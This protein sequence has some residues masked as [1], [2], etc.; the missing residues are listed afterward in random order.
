[1]NWGTLVAAAF[2]AIVGVGTTLLTDLVRSRRE[3]DQRWADTKRQV[4]VKALVALSQTHS[5][6]VR[7]AFQGLPDQERENAVHSAYHDSPLNNDSRSALRELA[8]TASDAVLQ[9]ARPVNEQLAIIRD[10]LAANPS[11]PE[12]AAYWQLV[13]P[14]YTALEALQVAMRDDLR[15]TRR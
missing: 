11:S 14:Y 7:A 2:G 3:S 9:L 8:I 10:A 13:Q 4:Y 15:P 5:R 1:M 12:S 6:M